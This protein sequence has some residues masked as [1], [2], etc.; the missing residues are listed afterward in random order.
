VAGGNREGCPTG[1]TVGAG[2][3]APSSATSIGAAARWQAGHSAQSCF[4]LGGWPGVLV[5]GPAPWAPS[6]WQMNWPP[7]NAATSAWAESRPWDGSNGPVA[8]CASS[9][10]T[11]ASTRGR[12]S[13]AL[14]VWRATGIVDVPTLP[15]RAGRACRQAKRLPSFRHGMMAL[16]AQQD[17]ARTLDPCRIA[18]VMNDPLA[19]NLP[20]KICITH[21]TKWYRSSPSQVIHEPP[22]V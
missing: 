5:P 3:V 4:C 9:T 15:R 17:H 19:G 22:G 1:T 8:H 21:L 20:P 2:R 12:W 18:E 13:M 10:S 16:L 6:E 7:N 14:R 11:A